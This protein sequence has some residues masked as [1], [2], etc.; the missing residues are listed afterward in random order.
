IDQYGAREVIR[1]VDSLVDEAA[2]DVVVST[3]HKAKGREWP[4]VRI[5]G[6]FAPPS[7]KPGEPPVE[8]SREEMMLA[9]VAVT[10]AREVLDRG[11]LA[12]VDDYTVPATAATAP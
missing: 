9:Y 11:G 1:L 7:R 10:R 8:V 4:K 5:A 2:A 6:D 3:A 12:W